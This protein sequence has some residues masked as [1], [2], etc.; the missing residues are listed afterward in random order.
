MMEGL[1]KDIAKEYKCTAAVVQ[2]VKNRTTWKRATEG[3]L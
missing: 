1:Y 2:G 3:I